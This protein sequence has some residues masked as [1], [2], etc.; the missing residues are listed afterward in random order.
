[1]A[2][3]AVAVDEA[4]VDGAVADREAVITVLDVVVLEKDVSAAGVKAYPS[5]NVSA[6]EFYALQ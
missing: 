1:M 2:A 3:L 5:F 6:S 4:D